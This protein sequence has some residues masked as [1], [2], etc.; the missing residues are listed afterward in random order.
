YDEELRET[1]SPSLR[2]Q[3]WAAAQGASAAPPDVPGPRGGRL[4][5]TLSAALAGIA[6]LLTLPHAANVT[7]GVV[8][9]FATGHARNFQ[10]LVNSIDTNVSYSGASYLVVL[11]G[12]LFVNYAFGLISYPVFCL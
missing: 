12:W 1:E 5:A 11:W 8:D 10:G 7:F 4:P 3:D 2:R 6:A 9:F